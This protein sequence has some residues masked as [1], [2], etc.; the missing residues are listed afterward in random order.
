[1]SQEITE[2]L[3]SMLESINNPAILEIDDEIIL[4]NKAFNLGDYDKDDLTEAWVEK[5]INDHIKLREIMD[6]DI[7]RLAIS[8]QKLKKAA[9]LLA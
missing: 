2:A 5:K 7:R 6:N 8:S 1:M 9:A 4:T 3:Q